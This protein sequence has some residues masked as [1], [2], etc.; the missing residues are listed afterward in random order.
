MN[1]GKDYVLNCVEDSE[2]SFRFLRG[3]K[4]ILGNS[5]LLHPLRNVGNQKKYPGKIKSRRSQVGLEQGISNVLEDVANMGI[6][7]SL[8]FEDPTSKTRRVGWAEVVSKITKARCPSRM[9]QGWECRV[10]SPKRSWVLV[11]RKLM[12]LFSLNLEQ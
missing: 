11:D 10:I 3:W 7:L 9:G 1:V 4:E 2:T 5:S 8:G 6:S 12:R